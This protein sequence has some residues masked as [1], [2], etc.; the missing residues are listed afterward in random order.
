MKRSVTAVLGAL[1]LLAFGA[2]ALRYWQGPRLA[3]YQVESRPLVQTVVATGRVVSVSRAQ[4]GSEI[5]GVLLERRVRE[6]D[7]VQAGDILAV[8][9]ADD[10]TAGVREAEAALAQLQKSVRRRHWLRCA[11]PRPSWTRPVARRSAGASC[12][13]AS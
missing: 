11:R 3:G 9:R 13:S 7:H 8:L 10:L 6:G 4:V 5:T 2:A 12:S 1:L